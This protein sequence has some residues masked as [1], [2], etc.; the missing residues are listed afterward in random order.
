VETLSMSDLDELE[1]WLHGELGPA[2]AGQRSVP[3]AV[4][5]GAKRLMLRWLDLPHRRVDARSERFDFP[6]ATQN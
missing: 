4:G 6:A 3:G 5:Q 1:R 2:V